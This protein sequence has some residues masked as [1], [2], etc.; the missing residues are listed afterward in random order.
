MN[1]YYNYGQ[2]ANSL[3]EPYN[4]FIKGNLFSNL[5]DQ[6]KNYKPSEI[7]PKNE[8]EYLL[9]LVQIYDFC[10]HELTLYLDNYPNDE[11]AIKLR[12]QYVLQKKES[13]KQYEEKYGP[14]VLSSPLLNKAPWAWDNNNFP[15][16]V[17]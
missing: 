2:V 15:W 16:E 12:E 11:Q 4:A 5:Y 10:A 9:L 1:N 7:N 3:E 6:Y 17:M 13:L 14:I 8:R